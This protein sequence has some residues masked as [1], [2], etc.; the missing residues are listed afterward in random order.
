[1]DQ[2]K[3]EAVVAIDFGTC[4]TRMAFAVK[5]STQ[6]SGT[7]DSPRIVV[8]D[9]WECKVD[10]LS[11]PTSI[12]IGRYRETES[13]PYVY[14]VTAYGYEAEETVLGP[15][16]NKEGMPLLFKNF[17]MPL[18]KKE[19]RNVCLVHVYA[20][21]LITEHTIIIMTSNMELQIRKVRQGII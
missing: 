2:K 5:P 13:H 10:A 17:K 16:M 6:S 4:N 11:A 19:V 20:F 1:M 18:H 14:D 21:T 7:G 9:E 3:T 8:M 12:L 15:G